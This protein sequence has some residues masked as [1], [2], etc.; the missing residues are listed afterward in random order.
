MVHTNTIQLFI[1][2]CHKH[3]EQLSSHAKQMDF[4]D[5]T[6]VSAIQKIVTIE[7]D[8]ITAETD[9]TDS[10]DNGAL[11]FVLCKWQNV[12]L[13]ESY[14]KTAIQLQLSPGETAVGILGMYTG[15]MVDIGWLPQDQMGLVQNTFLNKLNGNLTKSGLPII[16]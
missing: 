5:N 9:I 6:L 13:S 8:A 16:D 1:D 3:N 11:I 12:V 7:I 4:T 15:I 10:L 14:I 2:E